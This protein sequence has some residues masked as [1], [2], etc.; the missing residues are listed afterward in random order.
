MFDMNAEITNIFDL[1][2][3]RL[4]IDLYYKEFFLSQFWENILHTYCFL[5][6]SA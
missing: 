5:K 4:L 6:L 1:F 3:S 2:F